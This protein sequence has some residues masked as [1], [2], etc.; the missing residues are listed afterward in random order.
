MLIGH[1][2]YDKEKEKDK[3]C[4]KHIKAENDTKN[5]EFICKKVFCRPQRKELLKVRWLRR[6]LTKLLMV[7]IRDYNEPG[8]VWGRKGLLKLPII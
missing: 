2:I 1:A 6:F 7:I 3:A 4:M 5:V 8:T